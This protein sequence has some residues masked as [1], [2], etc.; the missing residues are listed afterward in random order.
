MSI[1]WQARQDAGTP[2][3]FTYKAPPIACV[4]PSQGQFLMG[5]VE[6]KQLRQKG[7]MAGVLTFDH[8]WLLQPVEGG[9]KVTQFEVDRGFYVWF[10]DDSWVVPSYTKTAEALA[11]RVS[12]IKRAN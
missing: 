1:F 8:Q 11:A 7:G 3:R 5:G 10:W 4:G 9:T 2:S 12:A 6:N